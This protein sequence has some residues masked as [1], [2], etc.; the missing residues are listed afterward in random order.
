[1]KFPIIAQPMY[2]ILNV[3]PLPTHNDVNK[4]MYTKINN[5]L[6][7]IN[8]DMRI[9]VILTKQ[10][11]NNCINN[12]NQYLCEKS[13]PIYHVNRNTPC[14]IKMYMRTQDNSEQCDIDYTITNCTIWITL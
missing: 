7:A 6:I 4:F 9:Y 3:I 5:K 11:L 1:L 13:Q 14:E 2:D 12:N 8:R 10:N